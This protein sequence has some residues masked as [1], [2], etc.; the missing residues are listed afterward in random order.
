[1]YFRISTNVSKVPSVSSFRI[2]AVNSPDI[3]VPLN[4]LTRHINIPINTSRPMSNHCFLA[5]QNG[6][7]DTTE[8]C[9]TLRNFIEGS[10][11][12]GN[13]DPLCG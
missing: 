5:L 1:M 9:F 11:G 12:I 4:Q 2:E 8:L 7:L 3:L 13:C 10:A 6:V